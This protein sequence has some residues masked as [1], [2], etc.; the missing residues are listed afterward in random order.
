MALGEGK[1]VGPWRMEKEVVPPNTSENF[2]IGYSC[3]EEGYLSTPKYVKKYNMN[4]EYTNELDF[5][6]QKCFLNYLYVTIRGRSQS[7]KH[8]KDTSYKASI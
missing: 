6:L 5:G 8:H 3:L 1:L 2:L 4:G 7:Q